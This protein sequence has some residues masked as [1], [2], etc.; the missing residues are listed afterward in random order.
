[1][2]VEFMKYQE[3]VKKKKKKKRMSYG[4]FPVHTSNH[5]HSPMSSHKRKYFSGV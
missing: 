4:R 3:L 5:T 1:M 2:A